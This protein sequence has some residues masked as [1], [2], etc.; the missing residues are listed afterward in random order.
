MIKQIERPPTLVSVVAN[1]IKDE[2]IHARLL[3]GEPL[4]EVELSRLLHVSRGTIREALRQ[5]GQDGL[6]EIIP[7]RGVFVSNLTPKMVREIYT[8]RAL[9]EPYAVRLSV[10]SGA[11]TGEVLN[12]LGLLVQKMGKLEASEDY[13]ATIQTDIR[14]H[15]ISTQYCRHNLLLNLLKNLQS[16]TLMFILNTKLY[17]S[18]MISDQASHQ[19]IF[20][21]IVKGDPEI[22]EAIVHQHIIDAG[23]SLLEKME[24]INIERNEIIINPHP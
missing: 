11:L 1:R 22:V 19:A 24:K 8:L 7:Y 10:E 16:M 5:L 21:S 15:E 23:R 12:K 9:L 14:F 18:D 2:I 4:H 6:V 3:P 13:A 17:R 20:D